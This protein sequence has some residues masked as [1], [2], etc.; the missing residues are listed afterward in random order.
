MQM[1]QLRVL[2]NAIRAYGIHPDSLTIE[3]ELQSYG[4]HGD[5]HFKIRVHHQLYS[6]RFIVDKRYDTDVFITLSDEVL[7]EQIRFCNY[8]VDSGI[9]FMKHVK[10]QYGEPFTRVHVAGREWRLLLFEWIEGEHITHC[11]EQIASTFGEFAQHIHTVSTGFESTIFPQLSHLEGYHQFYNMLYST[12]EAAV[13]MPAT[14]EALQSYLHEV[15]HHLHRAKAESFEFIVQSDLNP[16]NV[17]WNSEQEIVGLV[18]FESITYTDR[19]EALAW[20]IKWYSRTDGITSH[21]MSP[22]VAQALLKGYG[23]EE[24]CRPAE[25][26]RLASLVWLTGCLNWN[27]TSKTIELMKNQ[28]EALLQEHISRFVERGEQLLLLVQ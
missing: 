8:L 9:P 13:L 17:I 3:Q 18:D 2:Q 12:L 20:L 26:K 16:M 15:E 19:L 10:T 6:A 7:N 5:M 22:V 25:W 23:V 1:D 11:T 28:K 21:Q 4:K 27:F 14:K 24:M